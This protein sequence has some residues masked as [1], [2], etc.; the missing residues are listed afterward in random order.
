MKNLNMNFFWSFTAQIYVHYNI[1]FHMYSI[2]NKLY[3]N[4]QQTKRQWSKDK[5]R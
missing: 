4:Y 3:F 5:N 2:D 1:F